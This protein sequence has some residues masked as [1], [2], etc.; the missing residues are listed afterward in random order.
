M[1]LAMVGFIVGA[2]FL[3]RGY[4]V[5]FFLVLGL[6]TALADIARREGRIPLPSRPLLWLG[7]VGVLELASIVLA[8][9]TVR[10]IR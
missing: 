1:R 6:G 2:F 4:G 7:R 8:W 10:I 3:S 5:L 9:L